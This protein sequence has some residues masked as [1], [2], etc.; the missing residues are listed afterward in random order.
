MQNIEFLSGFLSGCKYHE[1]KHILDVT[2]SDG[3][4]YQYFEVP[5]R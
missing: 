4:V 5:R 2:G 1:Q 3:T